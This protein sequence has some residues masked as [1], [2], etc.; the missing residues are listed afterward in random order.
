MQAVV[1]TKYGSPDVLQFMDVEKPTP[2]DDEVLIQVGAVSINAYDWHLLSADIPLVRLMGGGFL[3]PKITIL[4]ADVAGR[5]ESV[6]VNVKQFQAGD[7]VFGDIGSG[8]FAEY[9]CATEKALALKP[10]NLSFEEAAAVPMAALTALQGL[11]DNG[12][13]QPGKKVL[14]Q[15]AS[16]GVGTFAVQI[17][18][19][20][21]LK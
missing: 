11:R 6:G 21:G 13:I 19:P 20:L 7:E 3:K 2:K 4:G 8:G 5:V 1:N 15:G 17:A 18:K 14:I 12:H 10:A 9:A 16:G